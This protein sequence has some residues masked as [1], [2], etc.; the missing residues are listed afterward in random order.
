MKKFLMIGAAMAAFAPAAAMAQDT[1]SWTGAHVDAIAGWDQMKVEDAFAPGDDYTK[2]GAV[3][4]GS[5]GFDYDTGSVVMGADAELTGAST[6]D[7]ETIATTTA[8]IKTGRDI[9]AGARL[10]VPV[11]DARD[12]LLYFKGGYTNAQFKA[13]ETTGT[14]VTTETT[15]EEGYRLGAGIEH[16]FGTNVSAKVEYR[17]SDYGDGVNRNQVVAGIGYRF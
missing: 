4:G 15:E 3:Y 17:Y 11:G 8:C 14:V 16:K 7:C 2:S 6:K 12:T 5:L 13:E 1:G 10:G 9:Y